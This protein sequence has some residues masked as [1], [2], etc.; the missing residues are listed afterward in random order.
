M[1]SWKI[2]PS[3]GQGILRTVEE[4]NGER[5]DALTEAKVQA[6]FEGLTWGG[7]LTEDV[8]QAVAAML[9]GQSTNL[10]NIGNRISAGV[11]G[12]A[13]AVIAY[14]NGQEEMAGTYQTEL[15]TSAETGDF[16]YFDEHGYQG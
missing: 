12:V 15:L 9:E 1:T 14:N 4:D 2:D 10:T 8:P 7:A 6:E 11:V 3:G 5:G 16:S 13:N